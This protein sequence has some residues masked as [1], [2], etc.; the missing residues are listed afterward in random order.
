MK[1]AIITSRSLHEATAAS[2]ERLRRIQPDCET[3]LLTYDNFAHLPAL[4][5]EYAESVDG[6]LVSGQVGMIS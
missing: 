5:D 6:F 3:V 2:L 4:Y 1:L